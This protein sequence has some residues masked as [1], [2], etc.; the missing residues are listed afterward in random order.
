MNECQTNGREQD[1]AADQSKAP[2]LGVIGVG[3]L[4]RYFVAGLRRGG[5]HRRILLAPR[6]RVAAEE[7]AAAHG[8][9]IGAD[10]QSVVDAAD[11]VLLATRPHQISEACRSVAFRPDQVLISV[12]AGVAVADITPA[13]DGATVVRSLPA[14]SAEVNAGPVPLFPREP[15]AET[16]LKSLGEIAPLSD[17]AAFDTASV[18]GCAFIWL[19]KLSQEMQD[20]LIQAGLEPGVARSLALHTA[21]GAA[22]YGIA[23]PDL[24]L[25]A[26]VNEIAREG[27]YSL[28]GQES[29][30]AAGG[31]AA[32][33]DA[34]QRIENKFKGLGDD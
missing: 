20:W 26:T 25:A 24:D 12:A 30:E 4:A 31:F 1:M 34:C 5:D 21:H 9:E 23:K 19:M 27:T 18:M 33:R 7:I 22:A 16:L 10:N 13:A 15:R 17:E 14:L 6:S 29:I 28:L 11:I 2:T 8:C 32:F 3:Q